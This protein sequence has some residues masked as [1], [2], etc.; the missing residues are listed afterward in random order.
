MAQN[1]KPAHTAFINSNRKHILMITNHGVHQWNVIPG[2]PDTGGQNVFVN[3]FTEALATQ[4]FKITIANRGGYPHPKTGQELVGLHYKDKNQRILYLEDGKHEFIRKEDMHEQ[5]PALVQFLQDFLKAEGTKIDL[6]ISHYWDAAAIG[7]DLNA[8]L[9]TRRKHIWVPHSVGA[10]KKRNV[11]PDKWKGLRIDERITAEKAA[12]KDLDGIAATSSSIRQSLAED[13][14]YTTPEIFLPP[15]VDAARY[16]PREISE[17]HAIWNFLS[18][19]STLSAAEIRERKIITEI[20]RTDSPKRK[21]VLIKAF[22]QIQKKRP[23]TLLIVTI[24]RNLN[25]LGFELVDLIQTLGIEQNVIVLGSVWEQLP[26]IYAITD[27]YCTPSVM[28]GFGMSPQEAAATR[29][30]TVSSNLVP[31]VTEYLLG[32][33]PTKIEYDNDRRSVQQGKAAIVVQAD[34]VDGFAF[35]LDLL[36]NNDEL[37]KKMGANAYKETIPYF[38]W[39]HMVRVFLED[40]NFKQN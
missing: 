31:Y 18:Q 11:S 36:L 12:I 29:V 2:L 22:A 25:P 33:E 13:Y 27:I 34:D 32:P 9:T 4:G 7:V 35:A 5:I 40:I 39:D 10:L 19:H 24:D 1:D 16:F 8:S 26:D 14:G 17:N 3:Q 30:P 21:Y 38:T 20:S 23:D 15:C 37:H 28:E 6:I